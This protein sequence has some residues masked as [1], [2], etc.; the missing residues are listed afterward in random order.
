[1]L[2]APTVL[3]YGAAVKYRRAVRW[4]LATDLAAGAAT[5]AFPKQAPAVESLLDYCAA[6]VEGGSC[7]SLREAVDGFLDTVACTNNG[8]VSADERLANSAVCYCP[9][10]SM[11]VAHAGS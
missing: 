3:L 6:F 9:P 2:S 8:V 10:A 4:T 7:C 11:P 1:M 5:A